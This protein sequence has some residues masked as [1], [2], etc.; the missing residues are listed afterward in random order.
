M[1]KSTHKSNFVIP[2]WKNCNVDYRLIHRDTSHS[3]V[4]SGS[5]TLPW[6]SVQNRDLFG[7]DF[8]LRNQYVLYMP[9][10]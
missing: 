3:S 9:N 1:V 8:H 4:G 7:N 6:L 10:V 5:T 2:S